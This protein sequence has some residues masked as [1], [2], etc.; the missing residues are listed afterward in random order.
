M[1]LKYWLKPTKQLFADFKDFVLDGENPERNRIFINRNSDVLFVAHIDTVIKPKYVRQRKTKGGKIKRVYA[2]GL[3]D[4][5]GCMLAYELSEQFGVDLLICDNEEKCQ[6]SGQFHNLNDYN[7]IAEFDRAGNDV[8][9]YD[10]DSD[11]FRDALGEYWTIGAG[12]FSDISQL[13]TTA[14]CV[15]IG[16][17]Y[18]FAHSKDS[19]VCIKTMKKQ[20]EKFRRFY[21]KYK[22]VKFVQDY[23]AK[24]LWDDYPYGG[25]VCEL[26]GMLGDVDYVFGHII[27]E[28]CFEYMLT[29]TC[30]GSYTK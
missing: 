1:N 11:A 25:G 28:Q 9:T 12:S 17:G 23:N 8:V 29:E 21:V 18:E 4:R 19:Y 6:S 14:C 13:V 16:I 5:L 24:S 30:L 22:D 3:D 7:W 15:N 27:C 20:I 26:C 10:L 2:P